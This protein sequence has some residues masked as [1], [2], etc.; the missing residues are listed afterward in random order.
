SA[1]TILVGRVTKNEEGIKS[2]SELATQLGN[3]LVTTNGNVDKAQSA[4]QAA[5]DLAGGKGKVIVQSPAPATADRLAQNLW[6]DTTG[7]ANT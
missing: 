3:S 1:T 5:N 2:T 6:I 4:A 7:N